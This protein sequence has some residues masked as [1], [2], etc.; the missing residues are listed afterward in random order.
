MYFRIHEGKQ[1]QAVVIKVSIPKYILTFTTDGAGEKT[2]NTC[3]MTVS[4]ILPSCLNETIIQS[5][6]GI[7]KAF[8]S[9]DG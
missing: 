4:V 9:L 8:T 1:G 2:E 6:F 5:N 7:S 3:G